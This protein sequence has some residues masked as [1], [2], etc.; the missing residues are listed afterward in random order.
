M[1]IFILFSSSNEYSWIRT[2][3]LLAQVASH[4]ESTGYEVPCIIVAAKDDLEPNPVIL[5]DSTKVNQDMG[6][7]A[8]ISISTMYGDLNDVFRRIVSVAEHPHL[9]IP[10]IPRLR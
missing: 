9:N 8:P 5:Q 1:C 6:L 10:K 3:R 4:V 7:E 2:K